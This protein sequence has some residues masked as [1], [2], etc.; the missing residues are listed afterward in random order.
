MNRNISNKIYQLLKM[1]PAVA[2]VGARQCGKTTLA[3]QLLP[4]W[5]YFDLEKPSD[6]DR[7]DRDPEFF[8][9]QN[10][11]YLIFDEAQLSPKLFEVLRT[12]IDQDRQTK[13]RFLITGSSSPQLLTQISETLAGRIATVELGT[14]KAN[15]IYNVPLSEFYNA[16]AQPLFADYFNQLARANLTLTEI[17]DAWFKGGYPEPVLNNSPLFHAQWMEN[18]EQTYI[19]R[20]IARLYP[21][22]NKIA[23]Q[24]FLI[25][26]CKLSGTILNKSEL[27]RALEVS[28]GSVRE[29]LNIAE[30]TFLWRQLR[31]YEN[32]HI[33]SLVKMPKGHIR[34]SGLLHSLLRITNET[35]LYNDPVVGRSFESFVIE[36]IIKGLQSL[37]LTHWEAF[38]Y[39]TRSGSEVDLVLKGP[40]GVL[41]IE[42]KYG[43]KTTAAQLNNLENFVKEH[44]LPFGLLINQA[45]KPYWLTPLIFQLPANYL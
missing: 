15:E 26:L 21:R 3:K 23:Y 41:P 16:F 1:F 31:S 34:D 32:T 42:I 35:Q 20:D 29:F 45:E 11:E 38:Y 7:I 6:F 8:F 44:N 25:M 17:K 4:D 30:G 43:I 22:L 12:V 14:L 10:Q 36:E 40:F 28:E 9:Q 19:Y 5:Q 39:R 2:V 33:K 37:M 18:Y 27:A 13:G 24:R